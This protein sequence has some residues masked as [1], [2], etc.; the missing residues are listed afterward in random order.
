MVPAGL[1]RKPPSPRFPL[2]GRRRARTS[3]VTCLSASATDATRT[4]HSPLTRPLP[5]SR[6]ERDGLRAFEPRLFLDRRLA[7]LH[8]G[9]LLTEAE[10]HYSVRGRRLRG[11]YA[12]LPVGELSLVSL[13]D[14]VHRGWSRERPRPPL[15][16][17][18]PTW[19]PPANPRSGRLLRGPLDPRGRRHRLPGRA[20]RDTGFEATGSGAHHGVPDRGGGRRPELPAAV[21]TSGSAPSA[22]AELGPWSEHA[23][24]RSC[25]GR[26]RSRPAPHRCS[27][28]TLARLRRRT[29]PG[30]LLEPGAGPGA[31]RDDA[32]GL[33]RDR[34]HHYPSA[35]SRWRRW[36][37]R[38]L[39]RWTSPAAASSTTGC[40][41]AP[42]SRSRAVV[43][44]RRRAALGARRR[45]LLAAAAPDVEPLAVQRALLRF[46]AARR[47]LLALLAAPVH[48]RE[49]DPGAHLRRLS[50]AATRAPVATAPTVQP[51]RLSRWPDPRL[52]APS[53]T[54]GSPSSPSASPRRNVLALELVPPEGTVAGS[55]AALAIRDRCLVRS[56]Q[57]AAGR[58][59]R[60]DPGPR[61][62][63]GRRRSTPDQPPGPRAAG[64][65]RLE[66]RHALT[67][68]PLPAIHVRRLL[69]LL[70]GWRCARATLRLRAQPFT[71]FAAASGIASNAC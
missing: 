7:G 70:S 2:A 6:L 51:L 16:W 30:R 9:S 19:S 67:P 62:P 10:H 26:P 54:R 5:G 41:H 46:C 53:T 64:L 42:G 13:P 38:P 40:V 25:R 34:V 3:T 1:S 56:G 32:A 63:R 39:P 4:A 21:S 24:R 58:D 68:W 48:Y 49:A 59:L 20:E 65:L 17:A 14:A 60:A 12:L 29:R 44:H 47:D 33:V 50:P 37:R 61:S 43:Q 69:I 55:M 28:G 18:P 35:S 71:A 23:S 8:Q 15:P 52:P 45:S 11:L 31:A 27:R 36:R 22:T 57:P 66:R